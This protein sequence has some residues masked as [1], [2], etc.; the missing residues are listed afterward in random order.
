MPSLRLPGESILPAFVALFTS[1]G[2]RV[3]VRLA[4]QF[5]YEPY[6]YA[7]RRVG[8]QNVHDAVVGFSTAPVLLQLEQPLERGYRDRA[9]LHK[10]LHC[11][12]MGFHADVAAGIGRYVDLVTGLEEIQCREEDA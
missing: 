9:G 1:G 10:A 3:L 8:L 12:F 2:F 4:V 7:V 5:L 11:P 6:F